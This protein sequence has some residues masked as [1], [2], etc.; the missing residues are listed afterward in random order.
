MLMTGARYSSNQ[1]ASVAS[2]NRAPGTADRAACAPASQ[3]ISTPLAAK[4]APMRGS[5]VGR[6]L[7]EALHELIEAT[8][9]ELGQGMGKVGMPLRVASCASA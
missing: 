5:A 8:A 2:T 9:A 1:S 6:R 3:R 4:I 7:L